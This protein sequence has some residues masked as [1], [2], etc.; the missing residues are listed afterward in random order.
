MPTYKDEKTNT[1]YCKFYYEDYT[2]TNKQKFKRGFERKKDAQDWERDFLT[3]QTA[4]PSMPF[5]IL[6][7]LYLDDKKQHTKEITYKTKKARIDTWILPY[8]SNQPINEI[9]AADI[10][11]WQGDIKKSKNANN[12]PLSPG[13]MQ[14]I[15]MELSSLF[16]FAVRFYG[17]S[18]NPCRIAG[19]TIG[20]KQKS[21]NFWTKEEFDCFISTFSPSDIYYTAF[22]VL[23][24]CGLRI[25]EFEALTAADIDLKAHFMT[26]I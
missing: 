18:V 20:K 25:G 26:Y 22:L 15:V 13:Y 16:N 23:Y 17:L 11:K 6:S 3:S 10:R 7:E 24:Y 5:K 4:Q 14:N 2:G 21:L 8:F 19:N 9:T 12:Q 1:W